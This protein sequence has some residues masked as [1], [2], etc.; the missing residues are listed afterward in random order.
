MND[1][2]TEVKLKKTTKQNENTDDKNTNLKNG[3]YTTNTETGTNDGKNNGSN[4]SETRKDDKEDK[5][6]KNGENGNKGK[7]KQ[8]KKENMPPTDTMM[9]DMTGKQLVLS[10][11]DFYI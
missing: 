2:F 1:Y 11:L 8:K 10:I 4:K 3:S 5:K 6:D 9:K 7:Q